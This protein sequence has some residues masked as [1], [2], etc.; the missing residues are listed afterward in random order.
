MLVTSYMY[1][2]I[3]QCQ[4]RTRKSE[5]ADTN[6]ALDK[7]YQLVTS[8]SIYPDGKILME[9]AIKIAKKLGND[10]FQALIGWLTQWKYMQQHNIKHRIISGV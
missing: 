5:Y 7:W 9:K 2:H 3:A 4:K 8:R 6:E 1:L 10:T